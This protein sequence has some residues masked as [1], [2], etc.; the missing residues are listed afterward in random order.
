MDS[1]ECIDL[2]YLLLFA[3]V[4]CAAA[5]ILCCKADPNMS[6]NGDLGTLGSSDSFWEV[7]P[8]LSHTVTL[9]ALRLLLIIQLV[10]T[11][12]ELSVLRVEPLTHMVVFQEF[13][14]FSSK[15]FEVSGRK[16]RFGVIYKGKEM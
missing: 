4:F 1:A 12:V 16:R 2:F 6:S 14:P 9:T 10:Q 15:T 7:K 13:S 11:S 8:L 5:I 3:T